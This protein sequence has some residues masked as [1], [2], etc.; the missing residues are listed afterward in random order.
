MLDLYAALNP[1]DPRPPP[2]AAMAAWRA[3][4]GA[5]LISIFVAEAAGLPVASCT[6]VMV[7]NITRHA[8][9]Y[10]LIESW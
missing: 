9:P 4:L 6:L 1:D 7:P 3:L 10:G 5:E 8:R 2:A